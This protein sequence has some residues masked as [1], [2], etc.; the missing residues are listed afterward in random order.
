VFDEGREE[1]CAVTRQPGD[2]ADG[3][4]LG[5]AVGEEVE[6][7]GIDAAADGLVALQLI[8][9]GE[10]AEAVHLVAHF[11]GADLGGPAEVGGEGFGPGEEGAELV[12]EGVAGGGEAALAFDGEP[13]GAE[14]LGELVGMSGEDVLEGQ[15][16]VVEDLCN[17]RLDEGSAEAW[18]DRGG[19]A[20]DGLVE[21][22]VLRVVGDLGGAADDGL[23]GEKVILKDGAEERVGAE[24]LGGGIAEGEQV[25]G[26][27]RGAG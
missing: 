22:L 11:G 17:R 9:G 21:D 5:V 3:A 6:G 12:V 2:A 23:G 20:E 4:L 13:A 16:V 15:L 14:S 7:E 25:G 26:G 8:A 24:A 19:A 10:A 27:V 1:G 18:K